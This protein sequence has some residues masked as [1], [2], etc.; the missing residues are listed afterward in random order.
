MKHSAIGLK[1]KALKAKIRVIFN[2]LLVNKE[3]DH[4]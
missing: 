3:H 4:I 1:L 2:I